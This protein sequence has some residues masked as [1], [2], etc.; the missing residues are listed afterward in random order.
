MEDTD[1]I[2]ERAMIVA[3]VRGIKEIVGDLEKNYRLVKEIVHTINA[4]LLPCSWVGIDGNGRLHLTFLRKEVSQKSYEGFDS[5]YL[6]PFVDMVWEYSP[7]DRSYFIYP[8]Q[9]PR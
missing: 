3:L 7:W 4:L 2:A 5:A 8:H 9:R 6:C 1:A